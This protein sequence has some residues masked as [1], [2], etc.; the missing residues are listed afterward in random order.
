[1]TYFSSGRCPINT[2]AITPGV[3]VLLVNLLLAIIADE[4]LENISKD[5][6]E[7][8]F[9]SKITSMF[10]RRSNFSFLSWRTWE[11]KNQTFIRYKRGVYTKI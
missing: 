11:S 9:C 6:G 10:R 3:N 5:N 2:G 8:I 7:D 4:R 1:M